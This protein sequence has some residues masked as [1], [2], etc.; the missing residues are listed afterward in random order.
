MYPP[1]PHS[2]VPESPRWLLLKGHV[3]EALQVLQTLAV[4]NGTKVLPEVKLKKGEVTKQSS[5]VFELFSFSVICTR[6][7]VMMA[8]W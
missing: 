6:T 7:F 2:L 3:E 8:C 1:Y 4:C 5:S